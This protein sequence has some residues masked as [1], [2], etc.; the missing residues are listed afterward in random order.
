MVKSL[1]GQR[2]K[3]RMYGSDGGKA[4]NITAKENDMSAFARVNFSVADKDDIK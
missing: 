3:L 2:K 1:E 4:V